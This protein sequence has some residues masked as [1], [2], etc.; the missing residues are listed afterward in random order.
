M[1][2]R[3][4]AQIRGLFLKTQLTTVI[5]PTDCLLG[6]LTPKSIMQKETLI[7]ISYKFENYRGK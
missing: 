6:P 1:I 4:E 7:V 5:R 2:I 3:E